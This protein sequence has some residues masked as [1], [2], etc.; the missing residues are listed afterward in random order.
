MQ[1]MQEGGRGGIMA[2]SKSC[3]KEANDAEHAGRRQRRDNGCGQ[4][5]QKGDELMR[6]M[7]KGGR[8]GIMA[9]RKSCRKEANDAEHAEKRQR[10]DT[11][12]E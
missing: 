2:A 11:G 1:S 4:K 12:C 9:A 8:G 5:L 10:R 3:G 6:S 7:Q